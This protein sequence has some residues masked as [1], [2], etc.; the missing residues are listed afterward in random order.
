MDNM[1]IL[2]V[3]RNV[4]LTASDVV[5][6]NLTSELKLQPQE[7]Q[8]IFSVV[9]TA[10]QNAWG[11]SEKTI[12]RLLDNKQSESKKAKAKKVKDL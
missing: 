8:K 1:Q 2:R 4:M 10:L 9:D 5:K 11:N 12:C 3:F 7:L 6:Q